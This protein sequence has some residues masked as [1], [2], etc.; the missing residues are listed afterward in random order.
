MSLSSKNRVR[1]AV[2]FE[3]AMRDEPVRRAFGL[4]LL[5]GLAKGQCLRLRENIRQQHVVMTA[6]RIQRLARTQ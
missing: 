5:R 6:E 2:A 3:D 1:R 4:H